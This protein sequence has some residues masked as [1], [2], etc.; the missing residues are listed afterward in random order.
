MI[1]DGA[2]LIESLPIIEYLEETR[3]EIP[4]LPKDPIQRAQ[5]RAICEL[6]NSGIQPLHNLKVLEKI[7]NDFKA[8]K[9]A[10]TQHWITLGL[11]GENKHKKKKIFFFFCIL[12][13]KY[14]V[15]FFFF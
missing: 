14:N 13:K 10:W 2:T 15:Y 8:D 7:N 1:I 12:V 3:P 11:Q 6:I 9:L 4:L 5:V